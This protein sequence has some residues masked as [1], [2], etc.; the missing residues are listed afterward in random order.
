VFDGAREIVGY[1]KRTLQ[2]GAARLG[3]LCHADWLILVN[4]FEGGEQRI[5]ELL[6]ANVRLEQRARDAEQELAKLK[7][8]V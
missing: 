6:E 8:T 1:I 3:N 7:R 2:P 4:A 5:Q